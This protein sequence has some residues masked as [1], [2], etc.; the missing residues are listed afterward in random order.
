MRFEVGV[1]GQ[2]QRDGRHRH[3]QRHLFAGNPLQHF[4]EVEPAVEPDG[5]TGRGRGEHAVSVGRCVTT[6]F[7]PVGACRVS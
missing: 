2:G 6:Q 7:T 1:V 4:I 5:G 3:L